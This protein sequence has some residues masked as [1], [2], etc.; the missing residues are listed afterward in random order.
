MSYVI[1]CA[2]VSKRTRIAYY[3][4][5]ETE[6]LNFRS[7]AYLGSHKGETW[8]GEGGGGRGDGEGKLG[9]PFVYDAT[10]L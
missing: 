3:L 7:V 5:C 9:Y 6:C 8:V 2:M 10:M 4:L 1:H